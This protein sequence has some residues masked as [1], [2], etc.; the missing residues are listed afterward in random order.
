MSNTR[1]SK[2]LAK[3]QI[4]NLVAK[5]KKDMLLWVEEIGY[6]PSIKEVKAWQHGYLLGTHR[7][8]QE[9]LNDSN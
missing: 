3:R 2:R 5:G 7:V 4:E 6:V 9:L 1:S 8:V